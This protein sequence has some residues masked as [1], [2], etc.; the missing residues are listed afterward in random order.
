MCCLCLF[1]PHRLRPTKRCLRCLSALFISSDEN[2]FKKW[3]KHDWCQNWSQRCRDD[4]GCAQFRWWIE[5]IFSFY[6]KYF[7]TFFYLSIFYYIQFIWEDP[8]NSKFLILCSI[9]FPFATLSF[10]TYFWSL[11][12]AFGHES[13]Q[14]GIYAE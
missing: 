5:C 3:G 2:I 8:F 1:L 10:R 13:E 11:D 4:K 12:F 7:L 6:R 9:S 14:K